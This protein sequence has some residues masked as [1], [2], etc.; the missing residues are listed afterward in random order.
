MLKAADLKD[1]LDEELEFTCCYF[2]KKNGKLDTHD[3]WVRGRDSAAVSS[4]AKRRSYLSPAPITRPLRPPIVFVEHAERE[5]V[6]VVER[7]HR[8]QARDE[9]NSRKP[10]A[11]PK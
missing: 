5:L 10:A 8:V 1:P 11:I 3:W 9:H 4:N 2:A 6:D 7:V